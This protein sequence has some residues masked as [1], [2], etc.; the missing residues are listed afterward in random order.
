VSFIWAPMLILLLAIPFGIALYATRERRRRARIAELGNLQM[1]SAA[2]RFVPSTMRRRI[3]AALF[4]VG[5]TVLVLALARPQSVVGVPRFE[6]TVILSF[7]VSGSMAATDIPPTRMEAAKNAA[8]TFV[9]RQPDSILVGVVAFSDAGF[10]TVVPTSDTTQVLSAIDRLGPERGTSVARGILSALTA[11]AAAEQ[12][13]Q[14]GYYS[15]RSP[16][17][18]PMPPVVPP[19]TETSDVIVLLSDGENNQ[20]PDPLAAAQAAA[21]RGI[22]IFTVGLG[23][24]EG[25]TL[26]VEGFKVHSRLDE[27]ALKQ[28]AATTG[29][30][31]YG[32]ADP[33]QLAAVYD[34]VQTK[35]VVKPEPMEVTSLFAGAGIAILLI[36][37]LAGLVWLG[38][39]P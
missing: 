3:P 20:R 22:R 13:P 25:T 18:V 10:S 24:A 37:G 12:D 28:I 26:D 31:Y 17:P 23:T 36:G 27:A 1:A 11:I 6:G 33:A 4:V 34:Q 39:M 7:D 32:A 9:A 15:N 2:G 30:T 19:G 8:R 21:E 14:A 16:D 35:L 5:M 38:R 29:G